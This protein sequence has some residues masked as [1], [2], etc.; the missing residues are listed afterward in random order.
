MMVYFTSIFGGIL[1]DLWLGKFKTI[2]YLSIV[3][4]FGSITLVVGAIP[5]LNIPSEA[6]L[7]MGL[8]L[9][10]LGNG[11]IKPCVSAFAGDQFKLP[12]QSEYMTKFFSVFYATIS[13]GSLISTAVTPVLRAKVHCFGED[14]CYPLAFGVP[15]I[16]MIT[17]IGESTFLRTFSEK[18]F[19]INLFVY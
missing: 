8:M 12:E 5:H 13:A 15:A 16:L 3:Y 1:C 7:F 9:I 11:G 14:D 4:C 10:S 18:S 17:S 6:L 2:L 19:N